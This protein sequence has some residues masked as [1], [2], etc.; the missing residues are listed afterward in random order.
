[1]LKIKKAKFEPLNFRDYIKIVAIAGI[2]TIPLL[3]G[4]YAQNL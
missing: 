2:V 1:M 4:V 3:I